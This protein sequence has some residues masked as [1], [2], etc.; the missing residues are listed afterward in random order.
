MAW[1]IIGF[2][3]LATAAMI[4]VIRDSKLKEEQEIAWHLLVLFIT[5]FGMTAILY[6]ATSFTEYN[7]KNFTLDTEIRQEIVNDSI[8]K[9]D[10]I[11]II[12]RK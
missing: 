6:F 1:L 12:T 10:T 7:N 3:I 2:V 11:Y 9:S 5:L 4:A 8:V